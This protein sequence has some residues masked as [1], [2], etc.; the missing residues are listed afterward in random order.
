MPPMI[1]G[2][3]MIGPQAPEKLPVVGNG[4]VILARYLQRF[5]LLVLYEVFDM[6]LCLLD[7]SRLPGDLYLRTCGPL[8]G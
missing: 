3:P 2:D 6:G 5:A 1:H 4:L 7:I 8:L